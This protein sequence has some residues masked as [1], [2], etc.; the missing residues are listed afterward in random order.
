M[1]NKPPSEIF[2]F[3]NTPFSI[4]V[5]S[6]NRGKGYWDT[7]IVHI[8]K[9]GKKIGEYK[10]NYAFLDTFYPFLSNEEWFAV[11]S[12]HYTATRI[13]KLS[14]CT[15]WCGEEP[16]S[17]G[18]C[19]TEFWVPQVRKVV[20]SYMRG[21]KREEFT[22]L[23]DEK[24]PCFNKPD[25]YGETMESVG[26]IHN[27]DFGFVA[28]CL[29]GDDGSWKLE[30]LDL[31]QIPNKQLIRKA[32]FGYIELPGKIKNCITMDEDDGNI[33]SINLSALLRFPFD[34]TKRA[35]TIVKPW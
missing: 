32:L 2:H 19:P 1:I 29:W 34:K 26:P 9:D 23:W 30:Y 35:D 27:T 20:W 14:D 24:N 11:Y 22:Q 10:R 31:S 21:D 6:V 33:Y 17:N 3:E 7:C 25:E 4:L 8:Y 16:K 12:P 13:M 28:G 15:D 5:E 18:F